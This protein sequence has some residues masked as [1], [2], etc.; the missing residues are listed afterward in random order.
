VLKDLPLRSRLGLAAL[1]LGFGIAL[2][3]IGWWSQSRLGAQVAAQARP[4]DI[5]MIA[6][7]TCTYC[8]QARAWFAQYHVPFTECLIERD[9]LC[10]DKYNALMAPGTPVM[11]VRGQR[12]VG[13]SAQAVADALATRPQ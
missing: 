11:L 6:S 5:Q 8:A 13:F 3:G 2:Q 7:V 12:L 10:A 9:A 1:V 4:G